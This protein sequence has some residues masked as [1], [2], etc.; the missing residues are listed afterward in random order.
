MNENY[1][2]EVAAYLTTSVQARSPLLTRLEQE[3]AL[4]QIP[5]IPPEVGQ[6]LNFFV[7]LKRP[8]KILEVGAAIGYSTLWL[9]Q[10]FTG[11]H[12]DTLELS[13]RNI[14][15][16]QK[17]LTAAAEQRVRVFAGDAL[18][19]L[20]TLTDTYDLIFVDAQKAQYTQY[21]ALALP[22]LAPGGLIIFDN[23]LWHGQ[24]AGVDPVL[25]RFQRAAE[26]VRLFTQEFLQHPQL[27][28]ALLPIGDGLGVGVK[29]V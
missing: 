24:V 6:V 19:I 29:H 8:Q 2:P 14:E 25:P 16:L 3:A 23:L 1:L 28:T 20:P 11:T 17:N 26:T 7:T 12:I 13:Q 27:T 15:R 22:I 4:E 9:A 5:I 21:L 18:Q 10:S